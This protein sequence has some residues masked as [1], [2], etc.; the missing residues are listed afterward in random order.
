MTAAAAPGLDLDLAGK[1]ALITGG[2]GAIGAAI[3]AALGRQG[4]RV[5]LCARGAP[6][7]DAA[8]AR[9]RAET[10]AEVIAV[11]VDTRQRA[12]IDACVGAVRSAFGAVDILV[13]CAAGPL[14]AEPQTLDLVD[15]DAVARDIDAKAMG[16]L[17]MSQAVAPPMAARGFGRILSIGGFTARDPGALAGARNCAL[18]HVTRYLAGRLGRSGVT[19]NAL[20]PGMVRSAHYDAEIAALAAAQGVSLA[21][22]E[23][24]LTAP[25]AVGRLTEPGEIGALAAFLCSP[26]AATV[27]GENLFI[28]GG[29]SCRRSAMAP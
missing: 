13:N 15:A 16:C 5:A 11:R 22:A 19:V 3:G 9:L 26:Y 2:S 17:R 28:D 23:A 4:A 14:V 1:S 20:H 18:A 7:L 29:L 10:S 8:A 6:A 21:E 25:T 12:A 27:T 24:A